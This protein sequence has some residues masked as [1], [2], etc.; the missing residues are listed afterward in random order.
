MIR[1]NRLVAFTVLSAG[2]VILLLLG[3]SN[4]RAVKK[5]FW[6]VAP[7]AVGEMRRRREGVLPPT[8]A[9]NQYT[10]TLRE[11]LLPFEDEGTQM[12]GP[13]DVVGDGLLYTLTQS[14]NMY[15]VQADGA[16][17]I[18]S[19]G[20]DRIVKIGA[21]EWSQ[22]GAV[23]PEG[24]G[25]KGLRCASARDCFASFVNLD[26]ERA[27]M[28]LAIV[29]L[30]R[31]SDDVFAVDRSLFRSPCVKTTR[32]GAAL[33]SGGELALRT[34]G[35]LLATVGD[36]SLG[37]PLEPDAVASDPSTPL[38]KV[39]AIN[40]S[41]GA[42]DIVTRGHRNPQ[43]LY[44]SSSRGVVF[45]TEQGPEG[46]DE[47]NLLIPGSDYGWPRSTY[48]HVYSNLLEGKASTSTDF[49]SRLAHRSEGQ[50]P[51]ARDFGNHLTGVKPLLAWV[52]SIGASRM[53]EY[54]CVS[55]RPAGAAELS[56]WCGNLL[57][58]SLRGQTLHRLVLESEP[59]T[60]LGLR[61]VVDEPIP[62]GRRLRG[63]R[64]FPNGSLVLKTDLPSLIFAWRLVP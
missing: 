43:G 41:T 49:S 36:F 58:A 28:F 32:S 34:D 64:R 53:L 25:F 3:L 45:S 35:T 55:G 38:G 57:V 2:S 27:C 31:G 23:P 33:T 50:P 10:L 56:G 12:S 11:L 9:T 54:E 62:F 4:Q 8:V 19:G 15:A 6:R 18:H 22:R 40:P 51:V 48:G 44:V 29:R 46:G 14:G 17:F 1:P 37:D 39:I 59:A 16:D 52:P 61:V 26:A 20:R 47:L 7:S 63:I 60:A 5:W 30:T 42:V 13:I 24:F 21:L